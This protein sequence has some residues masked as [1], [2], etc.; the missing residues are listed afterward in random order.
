MIQKHNQYTLADQL[1]QSK[2]QNIKTVAFLVK[3][4]RVIEWISLVK[5]VFTQDQSID[6]F[7]K[8]LYNIHKTERG[9][10]LPL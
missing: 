10:L 9:F 3:I 2:K 5:V 6:I 4:D 1:F 7:R 8:Y